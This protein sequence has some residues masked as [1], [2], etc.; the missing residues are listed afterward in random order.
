LILKGLTFINIVA[1][2][3]VFKVK[4]F[5][6]SRGL[7]IFKKIQKF[8]AFSVSRGLKIFKNFQGFHLEFNFL[9]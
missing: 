3:N 7:K 9:A 8:K 5:S 6:V 2:K 1:I 4:A